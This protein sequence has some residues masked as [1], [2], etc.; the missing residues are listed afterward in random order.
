MYQPSFTIRW[1]ENC[2]KLRDHADLIF[3][4]CN[5]RPYFTSDFQ[6]KITKRVVNAGKERNFIQPMDI[7]VK[8]F[9]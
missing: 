7:V 6:N 9:R 4:P 5:V 2:A 1:F 3:K 8:M